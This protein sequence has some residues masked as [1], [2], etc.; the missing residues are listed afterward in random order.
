[1]KTGADYARTYRN[2]QREKVERYEAALR[3]I[4][5]YVEYS[6]DGTVRAPQALDAIGDFARG[7]LNPPA[8][9]IET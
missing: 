9:H 5:T 8:L 3:E 1:M 7:A 2:K 6:F 4:N